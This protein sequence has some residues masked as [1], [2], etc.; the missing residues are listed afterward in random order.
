MSGT[1]PT[2]LLPT[3]PEVRCDDCRSRYTVNV[4]PAGGLINGMC[5]HCGA[6]KFSTTFESTDG[7]AA[8]AEWQLRNAE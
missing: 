3:F 1:D 7:V 5:P 4:P 8:V 2:P 6:V